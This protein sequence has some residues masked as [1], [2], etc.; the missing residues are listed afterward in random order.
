MSVTVTMP[1]TMPSVVSTARI[2]FARIAAHEMLKPSRS[3]VKKF[4][5]SR[6]VIYRLIAGDQPVADAQDPPGVAGDILLVRD[7]DDRVALRARAPRTERHDFRAGLGVEIAGRFVGQ[8][9]GGFVHQRPRHGDALALAAGK[10]VGFVM[11]AVGQADLRQG[12]QR[13]LPAFVGGHA[14][15]KS[16]A[17]RRCAARSSAAAG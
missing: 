6:R 17:V 13:G 12:F 9:D 4:M 15:R 3:S 16:A 1:M 2:L 11:H 5:A 10:F 7:D 8:Q 14:A